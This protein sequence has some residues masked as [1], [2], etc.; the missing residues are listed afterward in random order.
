MIQRWRARRGEHHWDS[1]WA[2]ATVISSSEYIHIWRG[3]F[4][5][6]VSIDV[7][8]WNIKRKNQLDPIPRCY[9][10]KYRTETLQAH[11]LSWV[12]LVLC[13]VRFWASTRLSVSV[14]PH[15]SLC[16]SASG[17]RRECPSYEVPLHPHT[18]QLKEQYQK[19]KQ[20]QEMSKFQL[21]GKLFFF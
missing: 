5:P 11:S 16:S 3:S 8:C 7:L 10:A 1:N 9:F 14:W 15:S 21:K 20:L 13:L 2:A 4:L 19:K 17:L 18:T 6:S 12:F